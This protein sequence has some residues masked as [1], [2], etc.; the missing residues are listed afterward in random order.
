MAPYVWTNQ[1][2]FNRKIK[3]KV[4]TESQSCLF[5]L[6]YDL[7]SLRLL[8]FRCFE[9]ESLSLS[10]S[11]SLSLFLSLPSSLKAALMRKLFVTS[12]ISFGSTRD[13]RF[14]VS[15][16]SPPISPSSGSSSL[17]LLSLL[18]AHASILINIY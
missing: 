10:L 13:L 3:N 17:L 16:S 7:D 6:T 15:S 18:L 4:E 12:G 8:S 14:F 2:Y 9:S 1:I 5:Y 11:F